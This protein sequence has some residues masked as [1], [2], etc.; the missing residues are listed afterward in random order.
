MPTDVSLFRLYA[1]RAGYLLIAVGL[2]TTVW[3][4]VINHSPQWPLMNGVVCSL[5]GAVAVLAAVGI[6][7]P[8]QM[9]PVLLF[10]LL[11]KSIWLIAVALPLWSAN[12]IDARTWETV[13]DCLFGAVLIPLI[14]WRYVVS[15]YVL[16]PGDHWR[17]PGRLRRQPSD[18]LRAAPSEKGLS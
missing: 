16:K 18:P 1:L 15:Q 4:L 10:E 17:G 8:L 13:R 2:A 6:R 14:P 9:L 12:Q 11:W 3:P 5:L 7:Y